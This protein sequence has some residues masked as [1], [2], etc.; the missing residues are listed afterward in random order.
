[1][2]SFSPDMDQHITLQAKR[3][4][5]DLTVKESYIKVWRNSRWCLP[6]SYSKKQRREVSNQHTRCTFTYITA[7]NFTWLSKPNS[8]VAV[9][10]LVTQMNLSHPLVCI[11]GQMNSPKIEQLK[12]TRF[13]NKMKTQTPLQ[14]RK[15]EFTGIV[16]LFVGSNSGSR[17]QWTTRLDLYMEII[18]DFSSQQNL[19][20]TKLDPANFTF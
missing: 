9:G 8:N 6:H 19:R 11:W 14:P 2:S 17:Y 1:M 18:F 12:V 5:I 3:T 20:K 15:I 4:T 16:T 7:R 10:E 13:Q